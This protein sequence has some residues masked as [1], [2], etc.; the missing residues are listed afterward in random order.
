MQKGQDMKDMEYLTE[1]DMPYFREKAKKGE[2]VIIYI[3]PEALLGSGEQILEL[4]ESCQEKESNLTE[5]RLKQFL[6]ENKLLLSEEALRSRQIL[7]ENEKLQ[8]FLDGKTEELEKADDKSK[9]PVGHYF[10]TGSAGTADLSLLRRAVEDGFTDD[11][12]RILMDDSLNEK[13][14]DL[15][16]QGIRARKL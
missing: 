14:R 7:E 13:Q 1:K 3:D 8:Q 16:Y 11:E 10:K 12:I 9:V 15:V 4:L 5:E 2:A 6:E